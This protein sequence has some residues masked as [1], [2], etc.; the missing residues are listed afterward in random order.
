MKFICYNTTC[1][2]NLR[3]AALAKQHLDKQNIPYKFVYG[4]NPR[5]EVVMPSLIMHECPESY[6]QLLYKTYLIIRHFVYT[7][8]AEYMFK[9]DEDTFTDFSVLPK[10]VFNYDYGGTINYYEQ[11]KHSL[12]PW[13]NFKLAEYQTEKEWFDL[14]NTNLA[15]YAN[16]GFYFLS[17]KAAQ[18]I[19][20][21]SEPEFINKPETYISE[22]VKIGSLIALNKSLTILDM[23]VK[24]DLDL[25]IATNYCS[26]HPVNSFLF[27]KLYSCKTTEERYNV[28]IQYDFTNTYH[29]I[30]ELL[31]KQSNYCTPR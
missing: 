18:H 22:D 12:L 6:S 8:N 11:R 28:L 17:R 10:E 20:S 14:P 5:I 27:S 4:A 30:N 24:T 13:R 7:S 23:S 9:I 21:F 25:E 26:V 19:L 3:I 1:P 29:K 16:G 15:D 2:K 31:G